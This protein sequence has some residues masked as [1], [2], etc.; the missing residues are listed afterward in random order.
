MHILSLF[1]LGDDTILGTNY[2]VRSNEQK[3]V[4][5]VSIHGM[6][7]KIGCNY[8]NVVSLTNVDCLQASYYNL[9]YGQR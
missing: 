2:W 8:N 1:I 6:K 4:F 7:N 9:G 5:S 3:K